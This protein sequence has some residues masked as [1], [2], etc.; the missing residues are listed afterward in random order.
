MKFGKCLLEHVSIADFIPL[1]YYVKSITYEKTRKVQSLMRPLTS[2]S[3]TL[4][5]TLARKKNLN[6]PIEVEPSRLQARC[7]HRVQRQHHTVQNHHQQ[8]GPTGR[9]CP[10]ARH[11]EANL[12]M[13]RPNEPTLEESH[14][15]KGQNDRN[16]SHPPH[17]PSARGRRS[18]RAPHAAPPP[19][20]RPHAQLAPR[21]P[22]PR[23][24]L[25]QLRASPP[26]RQPAPSR[27]L[28]H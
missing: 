22:G 19:A 16:H 14:D 23:V 12:A 9:G 6:Q 24:A 3:H 17:A 1:T 10:G 25:A 11:L 28:C 15:P 13:F 8:P 21:R 20:S 27:S 7:A 5:R 4:P 18:A 26:I 2:V